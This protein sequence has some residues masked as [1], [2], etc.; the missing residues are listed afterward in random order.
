MNRSN[1]KIVI[2]TVITTLLGVLLFAS[3]TECATLNWTD[4]SDNEKGFHV[5]KANG[6]FSP[7]NILITV[8]ANTTTYTDA[9]SQPGNCY[10]VSAFNDT[11]ESQPT[12]NACMLLLVPLPAK[13]LTAQ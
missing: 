8:P 9:T 1:N 3:L 12:N 11:G 5:W 13:D 4:N 7:F 10:R 6:L 2:V